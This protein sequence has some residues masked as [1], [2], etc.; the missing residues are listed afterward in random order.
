[1]SELVKNYAEEFITKDEVKSILDRL[2]ENYPA[3]IEEARKVQSGVIRSVLQELLHEK[4]PIKDMITILETITDVA[5]PLQNDIAL[6]TEQVRSKLSRVITNIFKGEDG[7]LKLLTLSLDTEQYLLGKLREQPSGKTLL[8]NTIEMQ[9]LLDTISEESMKILQKGIAPVILIVDPQLRRALASKLEQF[10][11]DLV[12][13]SH[14]ELDVNT[15]YEVLG[16]IN[17]QFN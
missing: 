13:L 16:S 3:I 1:M 14:A 10:K 7:N 9:K 12:V 17:I 15:K 4:I 6:I 11:I 2:A 8:L 5:T